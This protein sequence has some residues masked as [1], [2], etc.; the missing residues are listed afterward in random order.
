MTAPVESVTLPASSP[1]EDWATAAPVNDPTNNANTA[2]RITPIDLNIEALL[3]DC[4][5]TVWKSL[6]RV[7][8]VKTFTYAVGNV[9]YLYSK[10]RYPTLRQNVNKNIRR[11]PLYILMPTVQAPFSAKAMG[12]RDAPLHRTAPSPLAGA[13]DDDKPGPGGSAGW[14][15]PD[16]V[17]SQFPGNSGPRKNCPA[18]CI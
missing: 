16:R 15:F 13:P 14:I 8:C 6:M 12:W 7:F 10:E 17:A 3:K 5:D 2:V 4:I 1:R 18:A 9:H 11:G